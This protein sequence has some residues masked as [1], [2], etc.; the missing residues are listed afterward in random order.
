[1][2]TLNTKFDIELR[3]LIEGHIESI[4]QTM[5]GGLLQSYEDYKYQSG[6]VQGLREALG[7]CDEVRTKLEQR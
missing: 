1:M 6:V 4:S 7:L 5:S 3:K 2:Q